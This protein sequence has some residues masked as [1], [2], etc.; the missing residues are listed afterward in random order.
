M[1]AK[2]PV[3]TPADKQTE[4]SRQ[5]NNME[6]ELVDLNEV[7]G[8]EEALIQAQQK[9]EFLSARLEVGLT[10][11]DQIIAG[12]SVLNLDKPVES[13]KQEPKSTVSP[14][15]P[16]QTDTKRKLFSLA[17]AKKTPPPPP[18]LPDS[19]IL[20]LVKEKFPKESI[21]RTQ[22]STVQ[23]Q[24]NNGEIFT[25]KF[26][27]YLE[28]LG[29]KQALL[30]TRIQCIDPETNKET[31]KANKHRINVLRTQKRAVW[32]E[33]HL[34]LKSC[35]TIDMY[36][37]LVINK[38][39]ESKQDFFD[40]WDLCLQK[41]G[42]KRTCDIM[43]MKRDQFEQLNLDKGVFFSTFLSNLEAL[44]DDVNRL[45]G[46]L[47]ITNFERNRKLYNQAKKYIRFRNICDLVLPSIDT[48]AWQD[49]SQ[50]FDP[51]KPK[52]KHGEEL[53]LGEPDGDTEEGGERTEMANAATNSSRSPKECTFC[54]RKG[55]T[56]DECK[57]KKYHG[58][59]VPNKNCKQWVMNGR[60]TWEQTTG[61]P[62][63]FEHNQLTRN[64]KKWEANFK[65]SEQKAIDNSSNAATTDDDNE[66]L[67][68]QSANGVTTEDDG[69]LS[70]IDDFPADW[71]H[72]V[73]HN[74]FEV[75]AENEEQTTQQTPITATQQ[76]SEEQT[77]EAQEKQTIPSSP[78]TGIEP[79]CTGT[80]SYS[81]IASFFVWLLYM[82][83]ALCPSH[84]TSCS[85]KT[86]RK[87]QHKNKAQALNV[88]SNHKRTTAVLLDSGCSK[89]NTPTEQGLQS[90][91][92]KIVRMFTASRSSNL[93]TKEGTLTIE[94]LPVRV[95]VVPTFDKT[96]VSLGELDKMG[97]TWT[98]GKGKWTLYQQD[99]TL[100]TTLH[101]G[102]DNLY[103]F[104]AAEQQQE[105]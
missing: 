18:P 100:W 63:K 6:D 40:L 93:S 71:T 14:S 94:G 105:Q 92:T 78:V 45:G 38:D 29:L 74:V 44:A 27:D 2:G 66:N 24:V 21:I 86:K 87:K 96:L 65:R 104:T 70:L 84:L 82:I 35:L 59:S 50:R 43:M 103:H 42:N 33:A 62:C 99:G 46:S 31:E 77:K 53:A 15:T 9:F 81:K 97:I 37:E 16:I 68:E 57:T 54:K 90:I 79:V 56:V 80:M 10:K 55:H 30:S 36:K 8:R 7:K 34:H 28:C 1:P 41:T 60:C 51:Y 17:G 22:N 32:A 67:N 23:L 83:T 91:T 73:H 58:F 12:L 26:M 64:T 13:V 89:S 52:G 19:E 4:A 49:F 72:H 20:D 101:L 75:L 69:I 47:H 102:K 11:L 61:R 39:K 88:S 48:A 5:A 98:G 3:R 95:S 25:A 85:R 76:A